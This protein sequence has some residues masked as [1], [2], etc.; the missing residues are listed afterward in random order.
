MKRILFLI[1]FATGLGS[2]IA[3]HSE[4]IVRNPGGDSFYLLIDGQKINH[5]PERQV[6]LQGIDQ[7]NHDFILRFSRAQHPPQ[8]W[9]DIFIPRDKRLVFEVV[10]RGRMHFVLELVSS[11]PLF[12]GPARG[13][14][15]P[16]YPKPRTPDYRPENHCYTPADHY[17]FKDMMW[18]IRRSHPQ[19]KFGLGRTMIQNHCLSSRQIARLLDE[20]PGSE[21][22]LRLAMMAWDYTFDP[23]NF[24]VVVQMIRNPQDRRRLIM[25][26][27]SQPAY[28]NG[29]GHYKGKGK[30][31]QKGKGR[32][33]YGQQH[34]SMSAHEFQ[35]ALDMVEDTW[36]SREKMIV[37]K[38][39]IENNYLSSRQVKRLVEEMGFESNR[40]ELA[41]FGWEYVID[42]ENY[43]IVNQAFSFSSSVKELDDF[44]RRR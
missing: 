24:D 17:E 7:G 14:T 20:F 32:G 36:R 27:D 37:A 39:I 40:L 16:Y 5:R 38:Q 9:N 43:Y 25:H 4:V 3:G 11:E 41:K 2:L 15:S 30:G 33:H 26:I 10:P 22:R 8:R 34:Q 19:D 28:G 21:K 12:N 13:Q 18:E 35:S 42:P 31:H 1:I 44:M 6:V 23:E 29:N